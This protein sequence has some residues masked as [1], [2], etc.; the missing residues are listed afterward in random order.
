MIVSHYRQFRDIMA[1]LYGMSNALFL[2]MKFKVMNIIMFWVARAEIF[3]DILLLRS[4][5]LPL[6]WL[7]S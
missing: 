2:A 3:H 6:L 1:V 5:I 7:F 4:F